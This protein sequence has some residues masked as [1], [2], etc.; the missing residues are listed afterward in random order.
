MLTPT[1]ACSAEQIVE[2]E[3]ALDAFG[4]FIPVDAFGRDHGHDHILDCLF[5]K[6]DTNTYLQLFSS[7]D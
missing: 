1:G 7:G 5:V 6:A 4:M 3:F 2:R